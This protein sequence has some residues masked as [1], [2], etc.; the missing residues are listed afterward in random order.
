MP[1]EVLVF[2]TGLDN[3]TVTD[4]KQIIACQES[5]KCLEAAMQDEEYGKGYIKLLQDR[6]TEVRV[7]LAKLKEKYG[8]TE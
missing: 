8:L 4:A 2:P 1:I 6:A 7:T 5:L 3:I